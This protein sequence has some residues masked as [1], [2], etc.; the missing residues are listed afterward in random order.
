M[1]QLKHTK[2]AGIK[3]IEYSDI[4]GYKSISLYKN[5]YFKVD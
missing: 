5:G 4:K 1:I 3:P 2:L